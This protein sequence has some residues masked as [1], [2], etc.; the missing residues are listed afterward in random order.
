MGGAGLLSDKTKLGLQILL[1]A[2]LLGVLADALLRGTPWGLNLM[3][4]VMAVVVAI[5]MLVT[6]NRVGWAL[7]RSWLAIPLVLFAAFTV[8]RDSTVL[9]LLDVWA[10][11]IVFS[12]ALARPRLGSLRLAGAVEYALGALLAG[13]QATLGTVVLALGDIQWKE[14]PQSGWSR[15]TLGLG[16]GLVI[17]LPLLL[18]FGGLFMAA[19]AVFAGMV[20]DLF[21]IDFAKL[22]TH[23]SIIG[24]AAWLA[25][26]Y[27]RG[28]L[29]GKE[30]PVALNGLPKS[31]TLGITEVGI[32]LGLLDLLFFSFVVVQLRYLFG[33]AALVHVTAGLTYAQYARRGFFELVTVAA[34]LLPVLLGA[35]WLLGKEDARVQRTFRYLAGTQV[36]LLFVIMA[37]AVQRMR[38]YQNEYGLTELRL[39]TT[40]FMGWLAIVFLWFAATVLRGYR[41]RF[42]FGALVAGFLLL[43]GLHALNPDALIVRTNLSLAQAGHR[44]DACYAASLS[45]D[46]V[47]ALVAGTAKLSQAERSEA[48]TRVLAEW[49]PPADADWR[50]WSWSRRE[51]WRVTE[52]NGARLLGWKTANAC[53]RE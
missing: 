17:A 1:A 40:A 7:E 50:A 33:G 4:W 23:L 8:W 29:L 16:R 6:R 49:L 28:L 39:Y 30:A 22:F 34:L 31:L 43:G 2:L 3:L 18:V 13:F 47:P 9:K 35:H 5:V 14:L 15:R 19:D 48:A 12:L 42:A 21:D 20:K 51:A 52:E 53:G 27:L 45:A 26:G 37:S 38:L 32:A 24:L 41:E 25:G 46:A 36:L 11:M 10:L 44:F